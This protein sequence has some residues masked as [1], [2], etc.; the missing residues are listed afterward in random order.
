[1][2]QYSLLFIVALGLLTVLAL[3]RL[4]RGNAMQMKEVGDLEGRT[5]PVDLIA[6]RNL[7]DPAQKEFLRGALPTREYRRQQRLRVRVAAS[8]A[9]K[10]YANAAILIRL[11]E[12][13]RLNPATADDG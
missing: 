8:Y 13:L 7:M 6:F 4:A 10:V 2:I 1:M 9:K 3:R 12:A 11:G 5:T